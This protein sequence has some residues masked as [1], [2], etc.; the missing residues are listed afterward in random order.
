MSERHLSRVFTRELGITP[1]GYVERA[2][3]DVARGMLEETS[4]GLDA[5]AEASGFGSVETLRRAFHRNVGVAPND[6]RARFR[7]AS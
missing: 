7:R 1:A 3:I 2:R 6:Y 4:L 5:V